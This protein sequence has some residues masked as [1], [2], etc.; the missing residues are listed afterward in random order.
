MSRY[1]SQYTCSFLTQILKDA[2]FVSA[3]QPQVGLDFK[4]HFY[5]SSSRCCIISIFYPPHCLWESFGKFYSFLMSPINMKLN[6]GSNIPSKYSYWMPK[7]LQLANS[8]YHVQNSLDRWVWQLSWKRKENKWKER[9]A[10][11]F[12]A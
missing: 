2:D 3:P 10:N 4:N 12:L 8:N 1:N 5:M 6:L 7:L 9:Q 11:I